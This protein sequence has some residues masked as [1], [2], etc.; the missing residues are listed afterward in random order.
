MIVLFVALA[1]AEPLAHLLQSRGYLAVTRQIAAQIDQERA[2]PT[3]ALPV[4]CARV[5]AD[6]RGVDIYDPELAR[7]MWEG[8]WAG[9]AAY[10]AQFQARAPLFGESVRA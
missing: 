3:D 8:L 5:E 4:L 9:A 6:T 10:R 2:L 7:A 1:D